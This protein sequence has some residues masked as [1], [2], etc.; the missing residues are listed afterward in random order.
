[1]QYL[2]LTEIEPAFL[3]RQRLDRRIPDQEMLE[4]EGV[5][6]EPGGSAMGMTMDWHV[7]T[8]H[9]RIKL[10]HNY[11]SSGVRACVPACAGTTRLGR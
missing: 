5:A 1:M 4:A 8:G 9:A 7:T 3:T 6:W 10:R 2:G 11:R